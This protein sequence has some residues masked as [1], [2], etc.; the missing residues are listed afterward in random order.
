MPKYPPLYSP[1]VKRSVW[2]D[3]TTDP[4]TG[5]TVAK[6]YFKAVSFYGGIFYLLVLVPVVVLLTDP[7]IVLP[8]EPGV[9]MILLAFGLQGA[10]ILDNYLNRKT[11]DDSGNPLATPP[12]GFVP[13]LMPQGPD[14]P[15]PPLSS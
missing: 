12:P 11:A 4:R 15:Q 10:K 13:P 7:H 2:A 5:H 9:A 14:G 8:M 3:I 1:T 6:D